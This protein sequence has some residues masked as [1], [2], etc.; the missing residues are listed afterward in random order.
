MPRVNFV[1][2][3]AKDYPDVGIRK[4]DSYYWW[5]FRFGGKHKSKTHPRPSQLTQSEFLST[6][7]SIGERIDGLSSNTFEEL[8]MEVDE[9]VSEIRQLGEEQSDKLDNMPDSLQ[10]SPTGELLQ[11]RYEACEEWAD[12]L[13]SVDLDVKKPDIS[14]IED[15]DLAVDQTKEQ[16]LEELQDEYQQQLSNIMVELQG[17]QYEGE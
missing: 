17:C 3:A 9:I 4:G 1:K 12:T 14:D 8:E 10:E 6:Q 5:K 11:G 7:L 13:E 2:T 16:K 15:S